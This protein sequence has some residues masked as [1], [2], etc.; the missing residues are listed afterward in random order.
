MKYRS[1]L[2]ALLL[3]VLSGCT[4]TPTE[5]R[6]EGDVYSYNAD[7][8]YQ[9]VYRSIK[10]KANECWGVDL[11]TG[12]VDIDSEMY[13][14]IKEAEVTSSVKGMAGNSALV[15]IDIK[16]T[17]NKTKVSVYTRYSSY[18]DVGKLTESWVHG[19]EECS[20]N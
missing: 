15:Q 5:V 6:N 13:T 7:Q 3:A 11:I 8:S 1:I 12:S 14:D 16:S 9:S 18:S 20:V 4:M 17:S 2:A 10:R 19:N